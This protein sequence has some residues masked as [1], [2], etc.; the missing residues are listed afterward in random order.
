MSGLFLPK[1]NN[2]QIFG[3]EIVHMNFSHVSPALPNNNSY[4]SYVDLGRGSVTWAVF[5]APEE[6]CD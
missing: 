1:L 3:K 5:A 6:V 2:F 4:R